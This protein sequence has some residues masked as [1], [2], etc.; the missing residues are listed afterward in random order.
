MTR[1]GGTQT[2][3]DAPRYS[4]CLEAVGFDWLDLEMEDRLEVHPVLHL[5]GEE[6]EDHPQA[7]LL[8]LALVALLV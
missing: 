3:S 6:G 2:R 1:S 8:D 7:I 5:E 4:S